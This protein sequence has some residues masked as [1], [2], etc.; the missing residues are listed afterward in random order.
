M[1]A[2]EQWFGASVRVDRG[3]LRKAGTHTSRSNCVRACQWI[4]FCNAADDHES[5]HVVRAPV[6]SEHND[7]TLYICGSGICNP[8][9]L[10]DSLRWLPP[11]PNPAVVV[12][13]FLSCPHHCFRQ[14]LAISITQEWLSTYQV[15][16]PTSIHVEDS[17]HT[18]LALV[19]HAACDGGL[20]VVDVA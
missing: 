14:P 20:Q 6:P 1:T 13:R 19:M 3:V 11:S 5:G 15:V 2:I 17:H 8:I 4:G 12:P 18:L 9:I 7:A 10:R 16:L